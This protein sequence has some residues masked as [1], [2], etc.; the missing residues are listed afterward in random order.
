MTP[1]LP[2]PSYQAAQPVVFSPQS[3]RRM[4]GIDPRLVEIMR[5]TEQRAEQRGYDLE[6]SEG[7]RSPE[8]QAQMVAEGKSQTLKS[9]HL[10]GNALDMVLMDGGKPDW[11]FEKYREVADIAK[12]A[13]AELGVNDF[14]WGGD[15]KTLKDGVHFQVG[16]AAHNHA[17]PAATGAAA[18]PAG[19]PPVNALGSSP[20][21]RDP[22]TV[23]SL[24]ELAMLQPPQWQGSYLDPNMFRSRRF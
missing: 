22:G 15:W 14:V 9:K 23:N 12:G 11:D 8:R 19:P 3:E 10:T 5:L 7:L 24:L 20:M 18:V 4:E 6:V 1:R 13:A 2:T 16:G 17:P 21:G